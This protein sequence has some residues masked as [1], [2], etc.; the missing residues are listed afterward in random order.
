MSVAF[1]DY[2]GDGRWTYQTNDTAELSLLE[3]RRRDLRQTVQAGVAVN[4][5]GRLF[6]AWGRLHTMTAMACLTSL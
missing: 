4:D 3:P 6:R 1:A 5:D 2:D